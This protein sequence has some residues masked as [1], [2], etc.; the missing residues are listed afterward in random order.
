MRRYASDPGVI[1]QQQETNWIFKQLNALERECKTC[2]GLWTPFLQVGHTSATTRLSS[3]RRI[4][5]SKRSSS[6]AN[7]FASTAVAESDAQSRN[8]GVGAG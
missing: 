8:Q 2:H 4:F 5:F 1:L 6:S 3:S 7:H